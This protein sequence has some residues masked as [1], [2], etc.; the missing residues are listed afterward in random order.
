MKRPL[1]DSGGE[2]ATRAVS[3]KIDGL[4]WRGLVYP[5]LPI[6]LLLLASIT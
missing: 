1:R 3:M 5:L 6:L 2:G 4:V